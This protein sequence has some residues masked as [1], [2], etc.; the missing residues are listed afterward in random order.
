MIVVLVILL[1]CAVCVAAY[2]YADSAAHRRFIDKQDE[3]IKSLKSENR[4]L[5][6][7]LLEKQGL[8]PLGYKRPERPHKPESDTL[9]TPHVVT[10]REA[11]ERA[12]LQTP[13][14]DDLIETAAKIINPK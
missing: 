13:R 8:P 7:K 12:S 2:V 10:K 9:R 1:V 14:P 5:Y 6:D 3:W 4:W 11:E